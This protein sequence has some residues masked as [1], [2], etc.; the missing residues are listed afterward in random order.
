MKMNSAALIQR[1]HDT[2]YISGSLDFIH[3]MMLWNESMPLMEEYTYLNFDFSKVSSVKS[4]GIALLI[5]WVKWAE[6]HHKTLRFIHV[7]RELLSM[8]LMCGVDN[9]LQAY[10]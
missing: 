5:E 10:L 2:L 8:A 1:D 7:P 4:A 9:I 6:Q 3:V